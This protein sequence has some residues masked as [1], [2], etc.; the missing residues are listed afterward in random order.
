M[1]LFQEL[2]KFQIL[3]TNK[4]V[5]VNR[6]NNELLI[7]IREYETEGEKTYPTKKGVCLTPSILATLRV[8]QDEIT[9]ALVGVRSE[10]VG[11]FKIHVGKGIF[12]TISKKF[13]VINLRHFFELN[14]TLTPTKKGLCLK[15]QEWAELKRILKEIMEVDKEILRAKPC[16]LSGNHTEP[17]SCNVCNPLE[18]SS[19][20]F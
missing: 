9:Q 6:F 14:G 11:E 4:W 15:S 18:F 13:C 12:C 16:L 17:G 5:V 10:K 2:A 1:C 3:N 8:H 20:Y 19:N 7:H